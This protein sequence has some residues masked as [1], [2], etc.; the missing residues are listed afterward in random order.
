MTKLQE[1]VVLPELLKKELQQIATIKLNERKATE[2]LELESNDLLIQKAKDRLANTKNLLDIREA[3]SHDIPL[4]LLPTSSGIIEE[5]AGTHRPKSAGHLIEED[6]K[7]MNKQRIIRITQYL[8]IL[9]HRAVKKKN[10]LKT[11]IE[12]CQAATIL[13]ETAPTVNTSTAS[14]YRKTLLASRLRWNVTQELQKIPK[15][16]IINQTKAIQKILI[17]DRTEEVNPSTKVQLLEQNIWF[18]KK[19]M[20]ENQI[21]YQTD[22]VKHLMERLILQVNALQNGL[23]MVENDAHRIAAKILLL[24][25]VGNGKPPPSHQ[26]FVLDS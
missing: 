13:V 2:R 14:P 12:L 4:S 10:L 15:Q 21:E 5:L 22:Q 1:N 20:E 6:I 11:L 18:I 7:E 16:D 23:Q 26:T 24:L 25:T 3:I 9:N 17:T 19:G 8:E